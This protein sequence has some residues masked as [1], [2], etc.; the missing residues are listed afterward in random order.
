MRKSATITIAL[1]FLAQTVGM[2]FRWQEA[3]L[4]EVAAT[5]RATGLTLTGW[6][7]FVVL[8]S[9]PLGRTCT[10]SW[11]SCLGAS[12]WS[13]WFP[14]LTENPSGRIFALLLSLMSL[15]LPH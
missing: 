12:Y 10:K 4:V 3:G 1:S 9:I 2:I 15:G 7:Y 11:C 5:E 13:I 14:R 6:T 8:P